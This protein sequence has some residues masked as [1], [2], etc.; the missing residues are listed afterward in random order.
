VAPGLVQ[1]NGTIRLNSC[2]LSSKV[3]CI[4]KLL[5]YRL[6]IGQPTYQQLFAGYIRGVRVTT[7]WG[8]AFRKLPPPPYI[9][10]TI[11]TLSRF[12]SGSNPSPTSSRPHALMTDP[13]QLPPGNTAFGRLSALNSPNPSRSGTPLIDYPLAF[14]AEPLAQVREALRLNPRDLPDISPET[15]SGTIPGHNPLRVHDH[16]PPCPACKGT[17]RHLARTD[18]GNPNACNNLPGKRGHQGGAPRCLLAVSQP[19]PHIQPK[20]SPSAGSNQGFNS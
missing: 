17:G 10:H 15:L 19:P 20:P 11:S 1:R 4:G 2:A 5:Q 9:S 8:H 3:R 7:S 6:S 14:M 18:W 12:A 16:H 13:Y